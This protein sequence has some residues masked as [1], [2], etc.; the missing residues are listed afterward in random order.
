MV[1]LP[2]F[3]V[4]L[5]IAKRKLRES[6]ELPD[7]ECSQ[8]LQLV[9]NGYLKSVDFRN[10]NTT[11]GSLHFLGEVFRGIPRNEWHCC[12]IGKMCRKV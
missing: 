6:F 11:A 3:V 10:W 5:Q 7:I 8:E 1:P 4:E 2:L 9:N 12:F